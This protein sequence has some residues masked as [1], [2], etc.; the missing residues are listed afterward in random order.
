[1]GHADFITQRCRDKIILEETYPN[2]LTSTVTIPAKIPLIMANDLL[3]IKAGIK[4]CN[5]SDEEG[6]RIVRICNTLKLHEIWISEALID[7]AK[8]NKDIEISGA[9][10]EMSFDDAGNLI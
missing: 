10:Q 4:T 6:I 2:A 1:V 8:K 7:L 5:R 3:A 9:I